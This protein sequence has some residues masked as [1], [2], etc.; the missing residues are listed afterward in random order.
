MAEQFEIRRALAAEH[1]EAARLLI[2]TR[3]ANVPVIPP[4]THT[5]DEVLHWF[6]NMVVPTQDIWIAIGEQNAVIATMVLADG[7]IEQLYVDVA[8]VGQGIGSALVE[9]AKL[10]FPSGLDLWTF[11]SNDGAKR[12]YQRHGFVEIARTDGDNEEGEPDIRFHWPRA[13]T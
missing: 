9:Q 11:V 4:L 3:Q 10:E 5:D 12:F 1:E 13:A 7:W 2:R 8:S 6:L